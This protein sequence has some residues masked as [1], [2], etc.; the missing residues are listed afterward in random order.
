MSSIEGIFL[1]YAIFIFAFSFAV[2]LIGILFKKDKMSS[3][4][5]IILIIGFIL[6]TGAVLTRWI[7]TGH[8]PVM[9]TYENSL[10]GAWFVISMLVI[11]IRIFPKAKI[12]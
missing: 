3:I 6:L 11:F 12:F 7:S 1:W 2:H 4:S 10:F 5:N 9:G 8:I